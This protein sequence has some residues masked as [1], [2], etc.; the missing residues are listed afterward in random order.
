[1]ILCD[2]TVLQNNQTKYTS[3]VLTNQSIAMAYVTG[4]TSL[5]IRTPTI[6]QSEHAIIAY[7]T[8]CTCAFNQS[9]SGY[10]VRH[11]STNPSA[12]IAYVTNRPISAKHS[13]ILISAAPCGGLRNLAQ[14]YATSRSHGVYVTGC[15][16]AV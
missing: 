10:S 14:P 1:M 13:R 3:A 4:C 15:T 11:E 7:V 12:D 6:N 9:E 2:N 8:G 5:G 16:Y